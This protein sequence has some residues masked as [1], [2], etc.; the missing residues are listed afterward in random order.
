MNDRAASDIVPPTNDL[1][2]PELLDRALNKGIVV[3]GDLTLSIADVDLIYLGVK[4]L[5]SS[6]ETAER[7]RTPGGIRLHSHPTDLPSEPCCESADST[8]IG[9]DHALSVRNH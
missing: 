4:L 9:E 7:L 1:A 8:K 6:V 5:L 3:I 2:L